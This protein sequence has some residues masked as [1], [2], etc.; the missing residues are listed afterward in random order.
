MFVEPNCNTSVPVDENC[1][2]EN[3]EFNGVHCLYRYRSGDQ[4]AYI[5]EG[6]FYSYSPCAERNGAVEE[7]SLDFLDANDN[8]LDLTLVPN[9]AQDY[10][11]LQTRPGKS[12]DAL[13]VKV[14]NLLGEKVWEKT[15]AH[16]HEAIDI[17]TWQAAV[18]FVMVEQGGLKDVQRLVKH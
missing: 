12:E 3:F 16:R 10:F 11:H 1:C 14:F 6:A 4:S 18:Y 17:S 15:L 13:H 2:P 7:S 8:G 5:H 9:P